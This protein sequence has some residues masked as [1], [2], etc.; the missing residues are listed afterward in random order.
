MNKFADKIK[1]LK[2]S[3]NNRLTKESPKEELDFI[4][5]ANEELDSLQQEYDTLKAEKTEIQEMYI[6]AIR[7]TGS[8]TKPEEETPAA[9]RTLEEIG[10]E[11]IAKDGGKKQ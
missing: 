4:A 11:I 10:A 2:E 6:G 3:F 9:P 5:K 7:S 8:T 1:A